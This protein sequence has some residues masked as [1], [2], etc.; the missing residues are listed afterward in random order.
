M[1]L[2]NEANRLSII[3]KYYNF[4][5]IGQQGCFWRSFVIV[6]RFISECKECSVIGLAKL[7][8]M[9][10]GLCF[11]R[12]TAGLKIGLQEDSEGG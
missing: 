3:N 8:A 12:K 2:R 5:D 9:L 4:G 7:G 10:I 6:F 11:E 1:I